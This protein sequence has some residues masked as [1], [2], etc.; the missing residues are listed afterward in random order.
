MAILVMAGCYY[1]IYSENKLVLLIQTE[2]FVKIKVAIYIFSNCKNNIASNTIET[3]QI[4]S[5]C[6][7]YNT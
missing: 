6:G 2:I 4:I 1:Q 3:L 7:V 5:S